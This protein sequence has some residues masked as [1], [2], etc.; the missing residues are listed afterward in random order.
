MKTLQLFKDGKEI[1][2]TDGVVYVDGRFNLNSIIREVKRRNERMINFPYKIA[3]SF[4][5]YK[6]AIRNGYGQITRM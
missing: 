3:D 4:A 1:I 6:G 5:V 2:A